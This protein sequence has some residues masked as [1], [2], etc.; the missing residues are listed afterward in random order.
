M[1]DLLGLVVSHVFQ[2]TLFAALL[3]VVAM[4]LMPFRPRLAHALLLVLIIK[5][6]TPPLIPGP[7]P[8]WTAPNWFSGVSWQ[9]ADSTVLAR[10]MRVAET[11]PSPFPLRSGAP[12]ASSRDSEFGEAEQ[13]KSPPLSP[14]VLWML[15]CWLGGAIVTG[16]WFWHRWRIVARILG[17]AERQTSLARQRLQD[18][19]NQIADSMSLRRPVQIVVNDRA[20]GPMAIGYWR[21]IVLFPNCFV[22]QVSET[23]LDLALTHELLHLRRGDT[24]VSM[25]QSAVQLVWWFHPLVWWANRLLSQSCEHACDDA[26]VETVG[27]RAADYARFLVSV[28]AQKRLRHFSAYPAARPR[29]MTARRIQALTVRHRH[30][31][32]QRPWLTAI[33]AI[34]TALVILPGVE[35]ASAP[36]EE[37]KSPTETAPSPTAPSPIASEAS[38][39]PVGNNPSEL[40]AEASKAFAA[41]DWRVAASSYQKIV[42]VRPESP[43]AWFRLGYARQ[44]LREWP[45]AEEA[46]TRAAGFPRTR[47]IALYNLAC[48]KSIQGHSTAALDH[49]AD[50]VKHGFRANPASILDDAD[51]A[52]LRGIPRFHELVRSAASA[53]SRRDASYRALDFMIGDWTVQGR[54]GAVL[55]NSRIHKDE[56]GFLLTEKWR[57]TNGATGTAITYFD[58]AANLWRQ[59]F[60]G[61]LGNVSTSAGRLE[62]GVLHMKGETVFPN[63]S[64]A[65]IR[66]RM[67]VLQDGQ[68]RFQSEESRDGGSTW[69]KAFD[70]TYLHNVEAPVAQARKA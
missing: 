54:D 68:F 69:D 14:A 32:V 29:S 34:S 67:E 5:C 39:S 7:W 26:V 55:G 49:F 3:C 44:M 30:R 62:R 20:L 6:L 24:I 17:S 53:A 1:N 37:P 43:A 19:C 64:T 41:G 4:W 57:G 15:L 45:A 16:V 12:D 52:S 2:C 28:A 40:V 36:V 66:S 65:L 10:P 25:L 61:M 50:A 35:F 42:D 58:P 51:L 21:P 9:R 13:A 63:G 23:E 70:G 48:I 33:V 31:Q 18:R 46:Q 56:E 47:P 11:T 22:E 38:D 60:V 27:C 59:T 8:G